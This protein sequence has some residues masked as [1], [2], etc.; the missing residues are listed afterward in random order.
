MF[1]SRKK[2]KNGGR[3]TS[4][5]CSNQIGPTSLSSCSGG[6]VSFLQYNAVAFHYHS[7]PTCYNFG[8]IKPFFTNGCFSACFCDKRSKW[9]LRN[10]KD[11]KSQSDSLCDLSAGVLVGNS[12][13]SYNSVLIWTKYSGSF[14]MCQIC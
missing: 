13:L 8:H 7:A 3:L 4:C 10:I 9:M 11:F 6:D 1:T 5:E 14:C 2:K 12:L